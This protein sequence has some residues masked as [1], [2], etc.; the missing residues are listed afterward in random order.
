MT[1]ND[2]FLKKFKLVSLTNGFGG[3]YKI[4]KNEKINVNKYIIHKKY[5]IL[6][7]EYNKRVEELKAVMSGYRNIKRFYKRIILV[8]NIEKGR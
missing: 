6:N 5:E 8:Q 3:I 2:I 7:F 1:V 4:I